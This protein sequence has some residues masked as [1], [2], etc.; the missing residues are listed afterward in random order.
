MNKVE[1]T[2]ALKPRGDI[3]RNPNQGYQWPQ[4]RTG[5][6]VGQ[7]KKLKKKSLMQLITVK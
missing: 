5:E 1:P 3:T 6:C 2:L 7:K 4:N